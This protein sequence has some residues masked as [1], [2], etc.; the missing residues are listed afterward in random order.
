MAPFECDYCIFRKMR[1]R[2]PCL[3]NH[4]DC[5][6]LALIRRANLDA[7][8]STAPSTV[9]ENTR[10]LKLGQKFSEKLKLPG[11][12]LQVGPFPQYDYCGYEV[13][14][15]ML[16]YSL[17]KGKT[18]KNHTQWNTIRHLRSAYTNQVKSTSQS[19][20]I[21]LS[22]ND[23]SGNYQ[24]FNKDSC[25]SLWFEKIVEGCHNRMGDESITNRTFSIHRLK[26][27]IRKVEEK[28]DLS[29][30]PALKHQWLVFSC[31]SVICY[32]VSLRGNEAFLIDLDGILRHWDTCQNQNFFII[33]L[34]GK[35]KGEKH[36][37]AY[38]LAPKSPHQVYQSK[39]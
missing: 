19:N 33:A 24:R 2:K 8:W 20:Q 17:N 1:F 13:A 31:Y 4:G 14:F 25:G 11:P 6:L 5:S 12:Y 9:R 29:L 39:G 32:V 26:A 23:S 21:V 3:S 22:L 37:V 34:R 10:R 18:N 38:Y 36:D 16:L 7:F 35:I 27:V 15:Q 28:L 30:G